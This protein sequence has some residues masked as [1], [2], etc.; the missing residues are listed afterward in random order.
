MS[1][2]LQNP[3][4]EGGS[5]YPAWSEATDSVLD[6]DLAEPLNKPGVNQVWK[7]KLPKPKTVYL[8]IFFDQRVDLESTIKLNRSLVAQTRSVF[9]EHNIELDVISFESS[10]LGFGEDFKHNS[11]AI[12]ANS[13]RALA[14]QVYNDQKDDPKK[15]MRLPVIYAT[16]ESPI[17]GRSVTEGTDWLPFVFI[18]ANIASSGSCSSDLCTLAHEIG[19]SAGLEHETRVPS[20]VI[21]HIM[22]SSENDQKGGPFNRIN[23]YAKQVK[24]IAAAYFTH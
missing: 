16:T 12:Q 14:Q 21:D 22:M 3:W 7:Y 8:S 6:I 10:P 2:E 4:D 5:R 11:F 13:C 24:T 20:S 23:M 9:G 19:H 17:C 18:F 1:D 15:V